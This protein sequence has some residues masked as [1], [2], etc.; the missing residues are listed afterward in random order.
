LASSTTKKVLIRRF[1][2]E[3][4]VGFV[5]PQ[6]YQRTD[7]IEVLTTGGAVSM[8]PYHEVKTV[9]FVKDFEAAEHE[10]ERKVFNTRPKTD[11]L[12]VRMTF[13]D[14]E[15]MEGILPNNLLQLD[16]YGFTVVPPDPY[17]NNQRIFLPKVALKELQVLGVV[18][19]PLKRRKPKREAKDQIGLFEE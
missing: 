2:R 13:R 4:L 19:S 9:C 14:D 6:V 15:V 16:P 12:W 17:S 7:G 8:V 10:P 3:P 1:E 5:N 11:G 18:G